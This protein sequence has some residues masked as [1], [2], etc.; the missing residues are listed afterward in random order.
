MLTDSASGDDAPSVVLID[1]FVVSEFLKDSVENYL[2][3]LRTAAARDTPQFMPRTWG[4][5]F[6]RVE[7][8]AMRLE[9]VRFAANVR[10]TSDVALAEF[11]EVIVPCFGAAY[12]NKGRGFWCDPAELLSL[13]REA[14]AEG[15]ELLGSLHLHPDWHQ[16]GPPHERRQRVSEQPTEMDEYLF[17]NTGWPV[18]M[19]CYLESRGSEIV[20][21]FAAWSPPSF[22]DPASRAA[23]LPIRFRV[24][25]I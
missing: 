6:G 15:M 3:S 17:R 16:I 13:T 23:E 8:D 24:G 12:A 22:D 11:D 1:P 21:T 14:E 10:E 18:N 9:S 19:I 7:C 20:H 4:L 2:E 5:L 25:T